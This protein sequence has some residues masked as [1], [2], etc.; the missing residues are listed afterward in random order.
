MYEYAA[1]IVEVVDGDTVHLNVDLG[2]DQTRFL[3]VRIVGINAPEK[4]TQAGK[5][6]KAWAQAILPLGSAVVIRTVKDRTE[7]YGRYLAAIIMAQDADYATLAISTGHAV[8]WDGK[9]PRP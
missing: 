2:L 8:A 1:T 3:K 7:K 5:D 9:G 6:A 4:A